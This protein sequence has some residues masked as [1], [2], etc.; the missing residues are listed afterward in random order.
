M[1]VVL[2]VATLTFAAIVFAVN[3][4]TG[5]REQKIRR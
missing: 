2:A 5:G 1:G 4:L 3:W